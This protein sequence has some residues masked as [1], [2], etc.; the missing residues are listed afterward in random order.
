MR[1]CLHVYYMLSK[2]Q[3]YI[4]LKFFTNNFSGHFR[5]RRFGE[6]HL[7]IPVRL[8]RGANQQGPQDQRKGSQ[9]HRGPRHLRI[10]NF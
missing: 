5:S 3:N 8:D 6:V 1:A 2:S 7:R 4:P 10:R 9:V